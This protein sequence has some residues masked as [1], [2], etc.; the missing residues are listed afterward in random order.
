MGVFT[1]PSPSGSTEEKTDPPEILP[2]GERKAAMSTLD[3]LEAK[4]VLWGL[5]LATLTGIGFPAYY[6]AANP[7]TKVDGKYVAV[8]PDAALIGGILLVLCVIGFLTLW[9]RK[10]TLM[11]FVLFLIGFALTRIHPALRVCL[12][13]SRRLAHAASLADQQVRHHQFEAD[14]PGGR[15]PPAGPGTQGGSRDLRPSRRR[16]PHPGSRRRP[17]SATPRRHRRG[18]RSRSRPNSRS[19]RRPGRAGPDRRA[20]PAPGSIRSAERSNRSASVRRRTSERAVGS[21]PSA[22]STSTS[23][24]M[25]M[26]VE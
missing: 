18:R 14:R 17:A 10:R 1:G 13:L 9:K 23:V 16:A 7:L 11:A 20:Q 25:P 3:Q 5:I 2:Q 21:S 8:S 15:C 4:W 22:R 19:L 12:H 6:I 26:T 24:T